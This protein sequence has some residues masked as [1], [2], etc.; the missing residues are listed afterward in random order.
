MLASQQ[1]LNRCGEEVASWIGTG[2]ADSEL[3]VDASPV[4]DD[5][6]I[7]EDEDFGGSLS[8]K[9]IG[10]FVARV[11]KQRE[12]DFVPAGEMADF[13][14]SVLRVGIEADEGD[15]SSGV[16]LGKF[17]QARAIKL[18][19]RTLGAEKRDDCWRNLPADA[20]LPDSHADESWR[21]GGQPATRWRPPQHSRCFA[22]ATLP[23][24]VPTRASTT[25]RQ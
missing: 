20:R 10:N 5:V 8:A 3:I 14:W 23:T 4:T 18:G 13:G 21:S 17:D 25:R 1:L 19:Q 22:P 11:L 12:I 24:L 7:V 2:V 16:L 15:T 9:L 6:P